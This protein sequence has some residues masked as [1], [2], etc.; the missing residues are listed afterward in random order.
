MPTFGICTSPDHSAVMKEAGFDYVEGSCQ[1]YFRATEPDVE[2]RSYAADC[3]L[4]IPACNMLV[5]GH[6]KIVGPGRDA[7]A[8]HDYIARL[9]ERAG[10]AKVETVVFGSGG[11]RGIPDGYP[12]D[13]ARDDILAF[14]RDA[15]PVAVRHGVTIVA[16]PLNRGECN[17]INGVAEA[18]EYVR[19]IASPGFK[20]LVDSYHSWKED[21]PPADVEAA[22]PS[23]KHVH[24]AD[25]D[26]RTAPG[27]SG[28]GGGGGD[29][30]AMYREFFAVLKRGGYD[31]RISVEGKVDYDADALRRT[32]GFLKEQWAS[33]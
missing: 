15:A 18:M 12:R 13:G 3:A 4:P 10:Q 20:C 23:I 6:L 30:A 32:L 27:E 19:A 11:A 22:M 14:L 28:G 9:L 31:G 24:V 8:L 25:R 29:V 16:E 26:G 21:E 7:A 1:A 2:W 17:V 33:V 5:P